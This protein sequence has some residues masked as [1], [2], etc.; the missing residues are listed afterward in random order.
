MA[1]NHEVRIDARREYMSSATNPV[2]MAQDA[3]LKAE[4]D[5]DNRRGNTKPTGPVP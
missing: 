3:C 2:V 5:K 4:S 1:G